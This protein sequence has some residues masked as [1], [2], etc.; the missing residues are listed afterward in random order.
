MFSV[1]HVDK[2]KITFKLV[3]NSRRVSRT[4]IIG[5][6]ARYRT[7]ARRLRNTGVYRRTWLGRSKKWL[8]PVV[9]LALQKKRQATQP[10]VKLQKP[11]S[12]VAVMLLISRYFMLPVKRRW[13]ENIWRSFR[14]KQVY[15]WIFLFYR[16]WRCLVCS[17][18]IS[19]FW[20]KFLCS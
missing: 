11:E 13:A 19:T 2:Y 3:I 9:E 17:R 10:V 12:A 1:W 4:A 18:W 6:R 15:I 16:M 8:V 7:A 5:A 20:R 14:P